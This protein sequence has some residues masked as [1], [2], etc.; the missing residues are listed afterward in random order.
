MALAYKNDIDE[1]LYVL[2]V[3]LA[4]FSAGTAALLLGETIV[5]ELVY[6]LPTAALAVVPVVEFSGRAGTLCA[7]TCIASAFG[8]LLGMPFVLVLEPLLCKTLGPDYTAVF[9]VFLFADVG[10]VSLMMLTQ[11]KATN[12]R[13]KAS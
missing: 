7:Q 11:L 4:V 1:R 5:C 8:C 12:S 6:I 3:P 13:S 9:W 2:I 10:L